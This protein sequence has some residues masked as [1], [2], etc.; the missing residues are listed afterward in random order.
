MSNKSVAVRAAFEELTGRAPEVVAVAPGR[1][2]VIGEH[3]DY[4]DGFVLPIALP[5]VVRI[6]AAARADGRLRLHTRQAPDPVRDPAA[7]G[8]ADP[9]EVDLAGLEPGA[10]TGWAAY[11]AGVAWALARAGHEVRGA[12]LVVDGD[13]PRGAGL[14]SSAALECA[15]GSALVALSGLTIDPTELALLAQRAE[16]DFVGVPSGAM[17]QLASMLGADGH[18]L[19]IDIRSLEIRPVPFDL[20]AH[21]LALL[22]TDT[23]APHSLTDGAYAERRG[24]CEEAATALG[25]RALRDLE[26]ARLVDPDVA[27]LDPVVVRRVRHVVTENARVLA[28]VALLTDGDPRALG[29]LLTASHASLREDYEVSSDELDLAVDTALAH[30]ALGARMT[31]AGFGGSTIALVAA[32]RADAVAAEIAAA[33]ERRGWSRPTSFQ[34]V[35]SAGAHVD[36]RP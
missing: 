17:D 24:A 18:A 1:V 33:F 7:P 19:F 15:T 6:A 14:S 16:N 28:A 26:V 30:G 35:A 20:A 27:A 2:N 31:G 34:A 29:P 4:N 3:T 23:R 36:T 12:D 32:E 21:G 13:V 11:V 9:V 22:V 25:V 10:V 8:P 5:L